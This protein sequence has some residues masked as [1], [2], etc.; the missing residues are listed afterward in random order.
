MK[1][2][3]LFA[4]LFLTGIC[5]YGQN[6]IGYNYQEIKK[7]MKENRKEMSF[8]NVSNSKFNYLKYS[9]SG[10]NQTLL[11]F[12]G[13]DSVCKSIRIIC[14]VSIKAEKE[15]EFNAIYEKKGE[16]RWIDKSKGKDYRILLMDEKWS[17]V[18]TIEPD[19]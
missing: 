2:S 16:N 7:Y 15:K 9:D 14:A 17:S 6:L 4:V 13:P 12:L 18:I 11:F 8:N 10:D 3:T 1:I 5:A 19:K